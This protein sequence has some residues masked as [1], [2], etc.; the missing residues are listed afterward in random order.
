MQAAQPNRRQ[1]PDNAQPAA[2]SIGDKL[3]IILEEI[4]ANGDAKWPAIVFRASNHKQAG[5]D[6]FFLRLDRKK[7]ERV[8][9]KLP[10]S[11]EPV[12]KNAHAQFMCEVDAVHNR[13]VGTCAADA[14]KIALRRN[15]RALL[16]AGAPLR[17]SQS[18]ACKLSACDQARCC[19]NV[20][21]N[22]KLFCK[23]ICRSRGQH[24]ERRIGTR[25][26]VHNFVDR[27]VAA[28]RNHHSATV[29]R[30]IARQ[31]RRGARAS[32]GQEA[33]INARRL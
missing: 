20:P 2:S 25:N 22:T 4:C 30:G 10:K 32:G 13:S 26:A 1:A 8:R 11:F 31:L 5:G 12:G 27:S 19:G 6:G 3:K 9:K 15:R 29:P 17:Q 24:S 16:F 21:R 33:G 18:D 7:R 23:D 28:A 14:Q